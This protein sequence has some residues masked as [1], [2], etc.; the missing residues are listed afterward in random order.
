MNPMKFLS[1]AAQLIAFR[2]TWDKRDTS[3]V[4]SG[5][6]NPKIMSA[7]QAVANI[8]DRQC[9]INSGIAANARCSIFFWALAEQYAEKGAPRGLTW[10]VNAGQG[11]R[12]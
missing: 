4:P 3:Y 5:I 12:G 6:D 8:G 2:L 1:A 10:L 11:G 9:V 7:R